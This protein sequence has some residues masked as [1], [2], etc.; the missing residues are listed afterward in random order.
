MSWRE[1]RG[2]QST[3]CH[4]RQ[5]FL[6]P[7]V[8]WKSFKTPLSF[9]LH[10]GLICMKKLILL[11]KIIEYQNLS[12]YVKKIS[13]WYCLLKVFSISRHEWHFL[14]PNYNPLCFYTKMGEI[15]AEYFFRGNNPKNRMMYVKRQFQKCK[16]PHRETKILLDILHELLKLKL[17]MAA[18]ILP[19][20]KG[21]PSGLAVGD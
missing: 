6:F 20:E 7:Y 9:L 18:H 5:S 17:L 21:L 8:C 13:R 15:E 11:M 12:K 4:R 14:N 19:S 10:C 3:F 16:K 2:Q 1:Q